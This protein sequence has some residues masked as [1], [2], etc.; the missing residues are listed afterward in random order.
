MEDAASKIKMEEWSGK[1]PEVNVKFRPPH[2]CTIGYT[3]V[4][5]HGYT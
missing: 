5:T 3:R 2:P 4:I 1:D